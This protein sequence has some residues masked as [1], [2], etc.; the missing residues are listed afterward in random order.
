MEGLLIP[1]RGAIV[2]ETRK[3]AVL[4]ANGLGDLMFSMPALYSL[5]AAYPGAEV[6]LLGKRWHRD[7]FS[8]R[9]G[10]VDRVE[11]IPRCPGVG[12]E[13]TDSPD[14]PALEEFF[15]RMQAEHFDIV[16]QMHGGG[17]NSNPFVRRL[18]ARV[19][20][21]SA[22]ADA[23]P[24]DRMVPYIYFQNEIMRYLEIA[25]LVGVQ[26]VMLEP[27]IELTEQDQAEA[28]SAVPPG[29]PLA[30]IHPGVSS[31]DRLW[32]VERFAAVG[33]VLAQAGA[34]VVVTGSDEEVPLVRRMVDLM[35]ETATPLAGVL[36][37]GGLAALIARARLLV[38]N[39]TG[40][41]HLAQAVGTPTVGIYWCFNLI[42]GGS[43]FRTIH[44]PV[45]SWML[46]CPLCG[47]SQV[48]DPCDHKVSYMGDVAVEDVVEQALDLY[49]GSTAAAQSAS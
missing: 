35:E 15:A 6:V 37:L 27:C 16:L 7:F 24:L 48:Y 36:S 13:E 40:P 33:D 38:S 3:I 30:V 45:V 49:G 4:R 18:G 9:P 34:H 17:R 22:T 39:D 11:V 32:P 44:R 47:R 26:P 43:P 29:A 23:A 14:L 31:I 10:P 41:L 42:N 12:A 28:A 5:R 19:T 1:L 8:G 20:A 2:P 25:G 46:E 21:G